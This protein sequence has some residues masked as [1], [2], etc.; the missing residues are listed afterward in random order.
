MQ[1]K[2]ITDTVKYVGVDD[3]TIDLFESLFLQFIEKEFADSLS[4]TVNVG[5]RI[6]VT[7]EPASVRDDRIYTA[8]DFEW[9][10]E[11]PEQEPPAEEPAEQ[12]ETPDT[13]ATA[14]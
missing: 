4:E 12:P 1:K 9:V 8:V 7:Y 10:K 11:L 2:T 6:T 14:A 3:K 13:P 5:D